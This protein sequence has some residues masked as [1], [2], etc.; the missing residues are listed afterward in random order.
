MWVHNAKCSS[1][2]AMELVEVCFAVYYSVFF[3]ITRSRQSQKFSSPTLRGF[4]KSI[5]I[6][7]SSSFKSLKRLMFC[8]IICSLLMYDNRF[9]LNLLFPWVL[10]ACT[11]ENTKYALPLPLHTSLCIAPAFL[12]VKS[13]SSESGS[14]VVEMNWH[15]YFT[16]TFTHYEV[17]LIVIDLDFPV[18]HAKE[19]DLAVW[20]PCHMSKLISL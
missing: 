2:Q 7:G 19:E 11:Y 13:A 4:T 18:G 15:L 12:F 1:K 5:V 8:P 14:H 3:N 17:S 9:F 10:K 6:S 20:W 16:Q